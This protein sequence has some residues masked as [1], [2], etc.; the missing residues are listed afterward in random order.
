MKRRIA[1]LIA[2][3]L[4]SSLGAACG[5]GVQEEVQKRAEEEV[6]KGRQQVEEQIEEGRTQIEQEVQQGRTQVEEQVQEGQQQVEEQV[7]G[8]QQQE[9]GGQGNTGTRGSGCTREGRFDHCTITLDLW[10]FYAWVLRRLRYVRVCGS[11]R[12]ME[13]HPCIEEGQLH[14][15]LER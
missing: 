2:A 13:S 5:G 7:Q 12:R 4:V 3:V 11:A 6:E 1:I 14:H 8:G 15:T 10:L 9:G